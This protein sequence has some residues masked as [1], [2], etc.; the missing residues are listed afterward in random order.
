[1]KIDSIKAALVVLICISFFL[2]WISVESGVV[3]GVS[4]ILTGKKQSTIETISGF[5]VPILANGSESRLMISIIKIFNPGIE[6]A[7]KKS[8]LIWIIPLMS[9]GVYFALKRFKDKKPVRLGLSILCVGIFLFATFKIMTTNLDK[10]VLQVSIS[11][12]LWLTLLGY[13]G[14]GVVELSDMFDVLKKVN[15][16]KKE[17]E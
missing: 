8:F 9:I 6:H 1:M 14:I 17:G 10:L 5:K 15:K 4:K 12:G 3:G 2:P 16:L 7:D 11:F 13:L